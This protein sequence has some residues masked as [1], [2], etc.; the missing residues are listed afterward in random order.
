MQVSG[1][2][3]SSQNILFKKS[4]F[5]ENNKLVLSALELSINLLCT[6]WTHVCGFFIHFHF[7]LSLFLRKIQISYIHLQLHQQETCSDI[8][9]KAENALVS[10]KYSWLFLGAH[11]RYHVHGVMMSPACI[12]CP[13]SRWFPFHY[14]TLMI[15]KTTVLISVR[16][17]LNR[18][19]QF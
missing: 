8:N 5:N 10:T 2:R 3:N 15:V 18:D 11:L 7:Y 16:A 1:R 19:L 14:M 17:Q 4:I 9:N 6:M 12:D 13:Y